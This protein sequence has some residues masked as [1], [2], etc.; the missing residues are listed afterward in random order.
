MAS[1]MRLKS[2]EEIEALEAELLQTL[3]AAQ[4]EWE[5]A[6]ESAR[7]SKRKAWI[8]ALQAFSAFVVDG[9]K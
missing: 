3:R 2:L 8:D 9:K 6:D 7:Q 4:H 5:T 1:G